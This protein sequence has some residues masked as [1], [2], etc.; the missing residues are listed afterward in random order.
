M[1]LTKTILS[2]DV[3]GTKRMNVVQLGFDNAYP[4]GGFPVTAAELGL[5]AK[6]D[7]VIP[8]GASAYGGGAYTIGWTLGTTAPYAGDYSGGYISAISLADGA[9][10][11]DSTDLSAMTVNV[12]VIGQ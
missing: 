11:G 3:V 4:N 12:L 1:A 5:R 7:A 8:A 9:V 6:V 10:A 2:R